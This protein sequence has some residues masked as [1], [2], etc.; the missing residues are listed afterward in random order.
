MPKTDMAEDTVVEILRNALD[1]EPDYVPSDATRLDEI[2]NMN[3][4]AH[5]RLVMEI[6]KA[7]DDRLTMEEIIA[8][9]SVGQIRE[10]LMARGKL[11]AK[12]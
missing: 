11:P 1:L 3:S 7:L 2:P 12:G 10:L 5:V 8:V 9:E 6:E 4:L